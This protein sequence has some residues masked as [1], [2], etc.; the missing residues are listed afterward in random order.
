MGDFLVPKA[1]SQERDLPWGEGGPLQPLVQRD[2]RR[3]TGTSQ[4]LCNA[5]PSVQAQLGQ[6][7]GPPS[8]QA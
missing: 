6:H 3:S 7:R 5:L 8:S 2:T 4:A 1:P